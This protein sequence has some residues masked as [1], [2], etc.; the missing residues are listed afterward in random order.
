MSATANRL[1]LNRERAVVGGVCAGLADYFGVSAFVVRLAFVIATLVWP[2]MILV[3]G[4][5]YICLNDR[6]K[7][8]I[9]DNLANSRV[10][11]HFRNVDYR[12]RLY[13]SRRNKKIAG[14]CGGLADYLEI[15]SFWVRLAFVLALFFVLGPFAIFAYI[16]AAIVMEKEPIAVAGEPH[17]HSPSGHRRT[18]R[19]YSTRSDSYREAP[20][21]KRDIRDCSAKFSDLESKLRRLEATITSKR[22]KLHSE[23]NRI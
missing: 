8:Q 6:P 19:S 18:H 9:V 15:N 5:L 3:Y 21:E 17:E 4:V 2:P 23:L 20:V 13:K 10:C 22:F 11:R 14:V 7:S 12:K 1:H 16:V